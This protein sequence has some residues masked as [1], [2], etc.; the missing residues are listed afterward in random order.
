ME[1]PELS[2]EKYDIPLGARTFHRGILTCKLQG[3]GRAYEEDA[4]D[5]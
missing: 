5:K 4:I 1:E 3:F 2:I